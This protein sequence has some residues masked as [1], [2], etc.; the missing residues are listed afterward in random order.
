MKIVEKSS[1]SIIYR[2]KYTCFVFGAVSEWV[3]EPAG[4]TA[5]AV[6]DG[7]TLVFAYPIECS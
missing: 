2:M 4:Y 3:N 5:R 1:S 6:R 7:R